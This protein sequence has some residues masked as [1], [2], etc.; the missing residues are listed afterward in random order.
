MISGPVEE[1]RFLQS[2]NL[3]GA[4]LCAPNPTL[5]TMTSYESVTFDIRTALW[6]GHGQSG[7]GT[8][9]FFVG[10]PGGQREGHL[11]QAG[12]QVSPHLRQGS[13]PQSLAEVQG[14]QNPFLQT[15]PSEQSLWLRQL[16]QRPSRQ[17]QPSPQS[18]SRLQGTQRLLRQACRLGQSPRWRQMSV[19]QCPV[20]Q[21]RPAPHSSLLVQ[22]EQ[23]RLRQRSPC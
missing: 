20:R 4:G 10:Y 9:W 11:P 1:C 7:R 5:F 6:F 22:R 2:Q 15:R 17:N 12:G 21:T 3:V 14:E 13:P 8:H 19:K 16:L 23:C 18:R